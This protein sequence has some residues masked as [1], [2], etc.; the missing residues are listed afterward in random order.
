[1]PLWNVVV[2]GQT[3]S[4]IQVGVRRYTTVIDAARLTG[5]REVPSAEL[6]EA[7]AGPLSNGIIANIRA[8]TTGGKRARSSRW[9]V[10]AART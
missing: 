1:L 3:R 7:A 10:A 6:G 9:R 5:L 2:D 8:W 4:V